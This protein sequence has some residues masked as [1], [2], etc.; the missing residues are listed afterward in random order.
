MFYRGR[1]KAPTAQLH[2]TSSGWTNYKNSLKINCNTI[3]QAVYEIIQEIK[4][5]TNHLDLTGQ[6]LII[7]YI[8]K[9]KNK[10]KLEHEKQALTVT[11][12]IAYTQKV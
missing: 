9:S 4:H 1:C 11:S 3:C 8:E 2:K 10:L 12:F 6:L 7:N 5:A